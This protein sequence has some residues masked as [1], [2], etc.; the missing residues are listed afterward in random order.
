MPDWQNRGKEVKM[1][2][3]HGLASIMKKQHSV[4]QGGKDQYT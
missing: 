3:M 1:E 2:R 4:Q